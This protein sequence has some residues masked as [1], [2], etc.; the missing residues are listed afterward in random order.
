MKMS[1]FTTSTIKTAFVGAA[2]FLGAS[3]AS[4]YGLQPSDTF[5]DAKTGFVVTVSEQGSKLLLTG[6]NPETKETFDV[7]VSRKGEVS[8]VWRG[9]P[10][11][12]MMPASY[13]RNV[14]LS[15]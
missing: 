4:A 9:Q 6:R 8:G 11:N 10:I 1:A 13:S 12:Y 7:T 5:T 14:T 2:L 15:N 3:A